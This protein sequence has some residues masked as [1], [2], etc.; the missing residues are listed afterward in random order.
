MQTTAEGD[1]TGYLRCADKW[2]LSIQW[3][4]SV[5]HSVSI[6]NVHTTEAV[7]LCMYGVTANMPQHED[8]TSGYGQ[9]KEKAGYT[10]IILEKKC[11]GGILKIS[12]FL[13]GEG[14]LEPCTQLLTRRGGRATFR[15]AGGKVA[16]LPPLKNPGTYILKWQTTEVWSV[17][18]YVRMYTSIY[19]SQHLV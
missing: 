17:H 12:T 1:V 16:P 9:I 18:M 14:G 5:C 19:T 7:R 4:L 2:G 6:Y 3:N 13:V 11:Q 10:G 15:G 8:C